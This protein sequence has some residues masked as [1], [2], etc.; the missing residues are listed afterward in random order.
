MEC[1][2]LI[3]VLIPTYNEEDNVRE[4]AEAVSNEFSDITQYDYEILFID[5]DSKD[6]TRDI[7]REMASND[8]R[9]KAIFNAK[10]YGQFNSPFYGILQAHGDCVI[11]MV[12]DFQDPPSLIHD[13]IKA[14]EEGYKIV[15]GQKTSSAERGF[16]A[17]GRRKYYDFLKKH[18]DVDILEQVTGSGL[19]DRE[20]VDILKTLDD[21]KPY[22]RGVVAE[23]G[24]KIKLIQFRQPPRR[25]GKSSNNLFRY[26]DAVMQSLT[27]YTK[28][29]VRIAVPLGLTAI[30]LSV[31]GLVIATIYKLIH[32][33]V[34]DLTEYL[35][36]F[37]VLILLSANMFFIGMVGE[38][39]MDTN[40]RM[41]KRPLVVES[42]RINY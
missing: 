21:S 20:F 29:G 38:Y 7:I 10:N 35:P 14:W 31:S 30:I 4:I 34:F 1:K 39:V 9:I 13:Y 18:S 17:W 42:E 11:T 5:N 24:Y 22:L 36:W 19:Y 27:A 33:D 2:K 32:W 37:I 25:A 28:I 8:S 23:M 6:S 26:Y 40:S 3:T 12:A 16:F 15:L 41:K